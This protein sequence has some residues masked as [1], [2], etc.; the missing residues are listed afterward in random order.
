[1]PRYVASQHT[2]GGSTRSLAVDKL[3]VIRKVAAAVVGIAVLCSDGWNL[4]V[5]FFHMLARFSE[6]FDDGFS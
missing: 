6:T 5:S 4:S 3:T 2:Q 1:M